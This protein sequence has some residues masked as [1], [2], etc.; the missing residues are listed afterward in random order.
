M[1]FAEYLK[2][3]D[4]EEYENTLSLLIESYEQGG[5]LNEGLIDTLSGKLK[6]GIDFIKQFAE[7]V[8]AKLIDMLKLFKDKVIFTFFNKIKWSISGL[9]KLVK[10]GY[11]LWQDVHSLIAEF[12]ASNKVVKWTSE[13]LKDLDAFLD[14]HPIIKR[15]GSLVVV[16]F[17][18]YQW[19]SMISF[20][21]DIE[22]D[23]D[24]S[25]L[26]AAISGNFSLSDLFASPDGV[27][28]L[29]F[30]ATGVLTGV[31]F[32]WPGDAWL[33]FALSI[34]YTIAKKKY[35]QVSAKII[36]GVKKYKKITA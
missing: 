32:P 13:K 11:R 8:G 3:K 21:G 30:I 7:L 19:T 4:W 9:T 18:I 27:K 28:M 33:L 25:T 10:K 14:K 22:F 5:S 34:V 23:F 31:S 35:P 29:M 6:S 2:E 1:R 26:F 15:A 24:Q 36:K 20:T 16:G 12:I 17:L